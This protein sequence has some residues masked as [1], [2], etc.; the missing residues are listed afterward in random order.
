MVTISTE[1]CIIDDAEYATIINSK[2]EIR[3]SKQSQMTEFQMFETSKSLGNLNFGNSNLFRLPA[4]SRFRRQGFRY[5][6]FGFLAMA[7]PVILIGKEL[8]Q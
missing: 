3:N 5:S 6:D 7:V 8:K 1:V 4:R 2:H